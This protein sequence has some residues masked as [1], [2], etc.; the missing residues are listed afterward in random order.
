MQR[1]RNGDPRQIGGKYAVLGSLGPG[2][3][4]DVFLGRSHEGGLVEI[5]LISQELAG[6]PGFRDALARWTEAARRS[7]GFVPP[8]IDA[9]PQAQRPWVA[10]SYGDGSLLEEAV[11]PG[12]PLPLSAA[13]ALAAGL[14]K[15]LAAAHES[16]SPY[17][18]LKPSGVLLTRDGPL[19]LPAGAPPRADAPGSWDFTSPEQALGCKPEP[20]SDMFSLGAVLAFAASGEKPYGTGSSLTE[21]RGRL[22][23]DAPELG[24]VPDELRPLIERCMAR[25][26]TDRPTAAQ[27]LDD[28]LAANPG[29][30][31][32]PAEWRQGTPDPLGSDVPAW[33][34]GGLFGTR[35]QA[36]GGGPQR[37][38]MGTIPALRPPWWDWEMRYPPGPSP[39]DLPERQEERRRK[40]RRLA[41]GATASV[42]L[43]GITLLAVT[44]N[45]G[46][47]SSGGQA[48]ALATATNRAATP[49]QAQPA[50]TGTLPAVAVSGS[51]LDW[52]GL[53]TYKI[54]SEPHDWDWPG[55]SR[56]WQDDWVLSADCASGSCGAT[57]S[58]D[59]TADPFTMTLSRDGAT[60][61]GSVPVNDLWTCAV[62]GKNISN[63][64]KLS[65]K[66]TAT[67]AAETSSG[68]VVTAFS[69]TMTW[70]INPGNQGGCGRGT[71]TIQLHSSQQ[72]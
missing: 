36:Q 16:G 4:G 52:K 58:G 10:I 40:C 64:T 51:R 24:S 65:V 67:K 44:L 38:I 13:I 46:S 37:E 57:L 48:T 14:A 3:G 66:I 20:A 34:L 31:T 28:L 8:G 6:R 22:L 55:T 17:G 32:W 60:Y 33:H 30:S 69:G 49:T 47:S 39:A 27:F 70:E 63:D 62:G 68:W 23:N 11:A 45:L 42:T 26:P 56:P 5:M 61:A 53:V 50:R 15:E 59:I 29:A 41:I 25:E 43:G 54:T 9:D 21:I 18:D 19:L 72:Y 7:G 2:E 1:L 12:R 35:A 71:Y